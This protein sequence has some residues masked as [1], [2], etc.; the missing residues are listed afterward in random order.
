MLA[1]YH[2]EIEDEAGDGE[3]SRAE[4]DADDERD[5]DDQDE[6]KIVLIAPHLSRH[7]G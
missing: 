1:T 3:T 2:L 7:Q 4:K 5:M 6:I